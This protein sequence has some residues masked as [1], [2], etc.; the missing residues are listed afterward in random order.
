MTIVTVG[1]HLVWLYT[2]CGHPVPSESMFQISS[3]GEP[4][5]SAASDFCSW[6]IGE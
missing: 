4:V 5:P 2:F 1:L 3:L 6:L